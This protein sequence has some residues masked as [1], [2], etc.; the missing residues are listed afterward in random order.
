MP[1]WEKSSKLT[2]MT[3][4]QE[5]P[6]YQKLSDYVRK[7][8]L[9]LDESV[10]QEILSFIKGQQHLTGGFI[11]RAG[12]PDLYYSLFGWWLCMATQQENLLNG[13]RQY[14][15]ESSVCKTKSSVD[16][17]ALQLMNSGLTPKMDHPSLFHHL[18]LL[19]SKGQS[20]DTSYRFFLLA[21]LVDARGGN[22][23]LFSTLAK[24]FF[25]FVPPQGIVPCSL[26][27][28]F[29]Y[30][31]KMTGLGY[32]KSQGKMATYHVNNSGFSAFTHLKT[33]DTLSTAVALFV[34]KE[35]RF[36]LRLMKPGC[37]H[38]I[39]ENYNQGAFLSGDGDLTRDL[40]YTF[41]GLLALGS[42]MD[43]EK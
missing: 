34:L 30:A 33:A 40:E 42:L 31:R 11:D 23:L 26:L 3:S 22:N 8:F 16:E 35:T 32:R 9:A 4:K 19:F 25:F 41:Y 38:F 14:L 27:S 28:A 17:L 5:I 36:D 1:L 43:H 2:A 37:L 20:M 18:K 29:T 39:Q 12:N 15:A 24:I 13:L 6:V 21:L 7:G 10:Q